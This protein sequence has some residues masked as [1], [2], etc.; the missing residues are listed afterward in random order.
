MRLD[1]WPW[2]QKYSFVCFMLVPGFPD[3]SVAKNLPAMWKMRVQSLGW[4]DPLEEKWQSTPV[5][6]PGKFH[7][8]RTLAGYSPWGH[9]ESGITEQLSIYKSFRW[10]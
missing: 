6:S 8:Q 2:A 1:L 7:G 5:F 9:K 3:G 10:W 4:E